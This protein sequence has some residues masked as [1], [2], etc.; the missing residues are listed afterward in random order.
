MNDWLKKSEKKD[1]AKDSLRKPIEIRKSKSDPFVYL[2]YG[3]LEDETSPLLCTVVK[4][5][6]G[7]GFVITVY[8]TRRMTG[9]LAWKAN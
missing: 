2:Y 6:N 7:D 8:L 5:L 9:E 3:K 4:H 1:Y